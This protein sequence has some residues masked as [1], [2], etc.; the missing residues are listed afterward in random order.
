[1]R[2]VFNFSAVS[3]SL[4][5]HS[6]NID[7]KAQGAKVLFLVIFFLALCGYFRRIRWSIVNYYNSTMILYYYVD[8]LALCSISL[9]CHAALV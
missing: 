6:T 9:V 7:C 3:I 2:G 5:Q 1:M 4:E 8:M